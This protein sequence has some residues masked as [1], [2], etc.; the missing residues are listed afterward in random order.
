VGGVFRKVRRFMGHVS[1]RERSWI[2]KNME[3]EHGENSTKC[4]LNI[5]RSMLSHQQQ[6]RHTYY[7]TKDASL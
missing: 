6:Q 2:H 3:H 1:R 7:S 5:E 4:T